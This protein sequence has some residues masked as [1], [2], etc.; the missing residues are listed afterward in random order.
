M[1]IFS[2]PGSHTK[3]HF[4]K[5]LGVDIPQT[6]LTKG[7][8][9]NTPRADI[10]IYRPMGRRLS[11]E[12]IDIAR[13]VEGYCTRFFSSQIAVFPN[14]PPEEPA[15]HLTGGQRMTDTPDIQLGQL[16]SVSGNQAIVSKIYKSKKHIIE[17]VYLQNGVKEMYDDA[18][19]G[20][21]SWLFLHDGPSGGY[22][23]N[24]RRLRKYLLM[25]PGF[26]PRRISTVP[27]KGPH[28]RAALK[29]QRPRSLRSR[30]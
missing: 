28:Q 5:L 29:K 30:R 17:F 26:H 21:H 13:L 7:C 12:E 6:T 4:P 27:R 2:D 11:G 3:N 20:G 14:T 22:A 15:V 9:P 23:H 24:I 8:Y 1:K 19:W 10:W 18:R 25:L 16:I